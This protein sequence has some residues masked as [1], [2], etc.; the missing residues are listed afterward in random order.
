C[1]VKGSGKV[2]EAI[3]CYHK[4]VALDPRNARTHYNLGNALQARGKLDEAIAC[5]EKAIALDPKK[6]EAHLNLGLALMQQGEF[7][8]AIPALR[9]GHELGSRTRGWPY[10]SAAWLRKAEQMLRLDDR[11]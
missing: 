3:A 5:F 11:L 2:D 7:A 9:R 10:P 6:T 4:A 1:T 8:R